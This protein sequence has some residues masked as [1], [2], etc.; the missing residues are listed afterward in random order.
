MPQLGLTMTTGTI[1]RWLKN[2]GEKIARGE[3]LLEVSTEKIN[4]E[5]ESPVGGTLAHALG[6]E[7][8]EFACGA[9]IGVVATDGETIRSEAHASPSEVRVEEPAAHA[10]STASKPAAAA[11]PVAAPSPI[12]A[13]G[14]RRIA[15]PA[16]RRLARERAI[17]LA[18]VS[19]SGP[20]GRITLDDVAA[21][22][23]GAPP[24]SAAATTALPPQLPAARRTIFRRMTEIGVLPLAQVETQAR[25]D[26]LQSLIERRQD[27]GWT[28][29]VV[30]AVARL[31]RDHAALRTD[32]RTGV[33][34]PRIDIGVAADTPFGLLVPVVRDAWQRTL[35][36]TQDEI[37]RLAGAAREGRL[38][39]AEM[40]EAAFTVSNVGPQGVERVAPLVDLPQT[41]ILGMGAA[42]RRPAVIRDPRTG[43]ETV[44]PA[45]M[46][47]FV[48][49]FD[50][51]FIDGAPAA[52][53]LA[54][55]S[56][57]LSDPGVLL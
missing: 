44:A 27:F 48:L 38:T 54:A 3:P 34:H 36:E 31:L 12:P 43:A 11:Q 14:E 20:R 16:A 19:G 33:P 37:S 8:D 23:A 40:G 35:R 24:A 6:R 45:W 32:A 18:M 57:A 7:G 47:T 29:F 49:S 41:A 5:V 26:V 28:A 50:H 21:A 10:A 17:D 9:V 2:E 39:A 4:Y 55:L 56:A 1:V 25:V 52:R 13:N 53:F 46:L 42:T 15:S 51:R 30:F 22:R